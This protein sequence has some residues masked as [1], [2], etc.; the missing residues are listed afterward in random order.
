MK[1]LI[2]FTI[3]FI[4]MDHHIKPCKSYTLDLKALSVDQELSDEC[5]VWLSVFANDLP[6]STQ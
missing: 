2:L 1:T 5:S 3:L 6:C 4:I